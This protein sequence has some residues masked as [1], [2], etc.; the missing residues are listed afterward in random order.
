MPQWKRGRALRAVTPFPSRSFFHS[1]STADAMPGRDDF[2]TYPSLYKTC[3]QLHAPHR[4]CPIH[5]RNAVRS[6]QIASTACSNGGANMDI[7]RK[8]EAGGARRKFECRTCGRQFDTFQ[9]LGGHRTSHARQRPTEPL[10]KPPQKSNRVHACP[11]CGAAFLLWQALGGHMRRH[12]L[13]TKED[14]AGAAAMMSLTMREQLQW[15][16][17]NLPPLETELQLQF[18]TS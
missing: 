1:P 6:L 13:G 7:F 12:R 11:V 17:L 3:T 2:V 14:G 8:A 18:A 4:R 5:T 16:D 9:A 10:A 15:L